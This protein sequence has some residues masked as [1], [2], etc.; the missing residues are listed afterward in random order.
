MFFSSVD[1]SR[2]SAP[3]SKIS[4]ALN[5]IQIDTDELPAVL[6]Q[7]VHDER[8]L[9]DRSRMKSISPRLVSGLESHPLAKACMAA[10]I[11]YHEDI[12]LLTDGS[13]SA[14]FNAFTGKRLA[15]LVNGEVH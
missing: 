10:G 2:I 13:R 8:Y 15:V 4:D 7:E 1:S 9:S 3:P 14:C 5:A 6:V 12:I 11:A